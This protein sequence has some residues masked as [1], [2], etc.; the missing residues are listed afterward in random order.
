MPPVDDDPY[1]PASTVLPE[2]TPRVIIVGIV[3]GFLM[4]AANAYLGSEPIVR[5]LEQDADVTITGRIADA[6]LCV[7]GR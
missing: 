6:A 1:I 4:T 3:L 2:V 7:R 5:A